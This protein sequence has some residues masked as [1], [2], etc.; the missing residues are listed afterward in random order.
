[1]NI[2]SVSYT[3]FSSVEDDLLHGLPWAAQLLYLRGLRRY[4]DYST[5]IVG[6]PVRRISLLMLCEL[7]EVFPHQG[8]TGE[9][10]DKSKIRRLLGWIE[11]A[12]LIERIENKD[13]Y[14]M[15]FLPYAKDALSPD[16][17]FS[18]KNKP[19]TNID[20]RRRDGESISDAVLST[21][22]KKIKT[23]KSK[24]ADTHLISNIYVNQ[25]TTTTNEASS[26]ESVRRGGGSADRSLNPSK[27]QPT[28]Q[29]TTGKKENKTTSWEEVLIFPTSLKESD[30][31]GMLA[32]L[33]PCPTELRQAVIDEMAARINKIT[34]PVGYIR[35]LV[36]SAMQGVFIP[37]A[38]LGLA[39]RR[40]NDYQ[41]ALPVKDDK[42]D[43]FVKAELKRLSAQM[44][45]AQQAGDFKR[46]QMYGD[47]FCRLSC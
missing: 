47:Q 5:A 44:V 14:L 1:M 31:K 10:P 32:H 45:I 11:R 20:Q 13:G 7:A 25:T 30:K 29:V 43:E 23:E 36:E 39:E 46:Y 15:F 9:R 34:S 21:V 16:A 2:K 26:H 42:A 35:K 6:G 40:K 3:Y 41:T 18:G 12:G 4:M 28:E 24:K 27:Q 17:Y 22:N 19:D 37:E 38:G 33:K 8:M